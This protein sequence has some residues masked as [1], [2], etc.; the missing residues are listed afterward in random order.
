MQE[1]LD[2]SR[3]LRFRVKRQAHGE[4]EKGIAR[5]AQRKEKA[6]GEIVER[7]PGTETD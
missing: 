4:Q 1:A 7:G 6:T 5:R 2:E 3:D